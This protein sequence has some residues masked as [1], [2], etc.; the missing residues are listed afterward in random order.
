MNKPLTKEMIHDEYS[1]FKNFEVDDVRSA[2]EGLK[3]DVFR[4]CIG[5][6]QHGEV[7]EV[8]DKW[9]PVFAEKKEVSDE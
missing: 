8:I 6:I 5:R 3:A 1:I 2:V 4:A 9:F 7:L